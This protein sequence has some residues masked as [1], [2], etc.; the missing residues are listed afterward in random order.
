MKVSQSSTCPDALR[1]SETDTDKTKNRAALSSVL[2]SGLLTLLKI[3]AGLSSN[4]IGLLSEALHSAL[5][6]VAAGITWMAVRIAARPADATHP[7]GHGKV[8]NLSAL[9]E[10]LLLFLTCGWIVW[11]AVDRLFFSDALVEP[12]WWVFAVVVISL[13]VDINRAAMLRRVAREHRSQALEAD[14]LHF[15]T[16]IW[17]SAVVLLG[18]ICVVI[19]G[20]LDPAGPLRAVLGKADA[21]AALGVAVI[22]LG[23]SG[24]LACRAVN[25]LMD[26]GGETEA[27]RLRTVLEEQAPAWKV[28]RL[29][30]RDS[31]SRFFVEL[32]VT[33]PAHLRVDDAHRVSDLLEE[34]VASALPGAE[35]V[36]H[37][38][39]DHGDGL[40]D[41]P[42]QVRHL[43]SLHGLHA[44]DT[45][46]VTLNDGLHV[47]SH[48]ELPADMPLTEAHAL[49]SAYE[50]DLV[51]RV[52]AVHV[53]THLEPLPSPCS[54]SEALPA[55]AARGPVEEAVRE[56]L[57]GHP[58]L[59][60][61]YELEVWM[62]GRRTDLSLRCRTGLEATVK[63]AHEMACR[64]EDDLRRRLH[65]GRVV[66]H[67]EP[68]EVGEGA[69][70]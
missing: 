13:A 31:G 40:P 24:K 6:M 35:S 27:R 68:G 53:V 44:H 55:S 39:P 51:R 45:T 69:L 42:A 29:R 57:S 36:V 23:V 52:G 22:V 49:V 25:S 64:L 3:A 54:A 48:A 56:A 38:E 70:A 11:E 34:I 4:S 12:S 60:D 8:E 9:A 28:R 41:I 15:T 16:D 47:F 18:L 30:V 32:T 2:W 37:L 20:K 43:A 26:G 10:T 14:A 19:A 7:F 33:A 5:D 62:A 1:S 21:V 67:V 59:E 46:L 61:S 17:S 58:H 66:I 50:A 63:E 65:L